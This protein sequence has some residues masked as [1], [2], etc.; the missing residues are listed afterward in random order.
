MA[1]PCGVSSA[2]PARM[3]LTEHTSAN[4][5]ALLIQFMHHSSRGAT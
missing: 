1:C 3:L 4:G 5:K 2:Q